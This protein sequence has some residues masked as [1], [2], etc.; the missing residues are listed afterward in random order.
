MLGRKRP[1][2]SAPMLS[3]NA[4]KLSLL[5][6]AKLARAAAVVDAVRNTNEWLIRED[7]P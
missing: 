4:C 7:M 3:R 2:V 1:P 6:N 5:H